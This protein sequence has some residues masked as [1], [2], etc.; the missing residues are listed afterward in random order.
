MKILL[1]L[2]IAAAAL[3][4][5]CAAPSAQAPQVASLPS[6]AATSS[7]DTS[8]PPAPDTGRPQLRLDSSDADVQ[9]AW[10]GYYACVKAHGHK[11]WRWNGVESPD[12]NDH[13]ATAKAAEQACTGKMP[14][15]PPE[16]DQARN[17]HYLDQYHAYLTCLTSH[18]VAVHA[19]DPF[20]SGW[21]FD[22]GVTQKLSETQ[23]NKVDHDCQ[24]ASFKLG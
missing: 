20:G 1:G 13:S 4:G 2:A 12:Q 16:L 11:M 6:T 15:E 22:D 19:T 3:L 10:Q 17:P 5:A 8:P 7:V 14:Q 21:T 24:L 18:D 9:Q 23:R